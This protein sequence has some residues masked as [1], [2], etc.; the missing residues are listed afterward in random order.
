MNQK[1]NF[2]PKR[3]SNEE[4]V[5]APGNWGK[6]LSHYSYRRRRAIWEEQPGYH[7]LLAAAMATVAKKD[8][9]FIDVAAELTKNNVPRYIYLSLVG[10]TLRSLGDREEGLEM[11]RKAVELDQ[12]SATLLS[13]AADTDDLDEKERLSRKV[14]N[15]DPKDNEALRH[16]AYSK[17]FK[18]ERDEAEHLI[19]KV[20]LNQPRNTHALEFKGN[21]YFDKEEWPLALEQYL[22]I[23]IKPTPIS[24]QLKICHC[25]HLLGMSRKAKRI[26]KKIKDKIIRAYDIDGGVERAQELLAE[27]L[28]S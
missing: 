11:T 14:L 28:A 20:L 27:I 15:D 5:L 21:V 16:L 7:T 9:H 10:S 24:L 22:K 12:S 19:D 1:Y 8:R 4:I 25:Y 18:G 23:K 6:V 26:A 3:L 13:L 17:Y 2:L